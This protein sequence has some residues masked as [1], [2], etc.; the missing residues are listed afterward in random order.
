M[1][2]LGLVFLLFCT[3]IKLSAKPSAEFGVTLVTSGC[4]PLTVSFVDMSSGSPTSWSWDF[5]NGQTSILQDPTVTFITAG[6]YTIRLTATN[7]T[8]SDTKTKVKYITVFRNPEADFKVNKVVACINENIVFTDNSKQGDA[9]LKDWYWFFGDGETIHSKNPTHAYKNAGIYT[10]TLIVTDNNNCINTIIKNNLIEIK[11]VKAGFYVNSPYFCSV[12]AVAIFTNLSTPASAITKFSWNF[13]DGNTSNS[14]NPTNPYTKNGKY[15]VKLKVEDQFGCS[16]EITKTN[17]IEVEKFIADFDFTIND[18]CAPAHVQFTNKST[19]VSGLSYDWDFGNGSNTDVEDPGYTY[20]NPGNY[21]V[22]LT[23]SKNGCSS[24]KTKIVNVYSVPAAYFSADTQTFCKIPFN[25]KFSI[26]FP[27][28]YSFLWNF[29]DN[30]SSTTQQPTHQYKSFGSFSVTLR[31]TDNSTGCTKEFVKNGYIVASPPDVKVEIQDTMGCV[32]LIVNYKIKDNSLIPFT[33]WIVNSGNGKTSIKAFDYFA[34]ADTGVFNLTIRGKNNRGCDFFYVKQIKV[35]KHPIA[36]FKNFFYRG[37]NDSVLQFTNLTNTHDPKADEF[38][39]KFGDG[40]TSGEENPNHK[41]QDTGYMDVT[42]IASKYG[43]KDSTVHK[44][45]VYINP[46]IAII[47]DRVFCYPAVLS[48]MNMSKGGTKWFWD[49]GDHT[50]STLKNPTHSYA[51]GRYKVVLTVEDENTGCIDKDS[52]NVFV[53]MPPTD[54]FIA[55]KTTACKGSYINF[56]DISTNYLT[57][58]W[59]FGNG[60]SSNLKTPSINY[61]DGGVYTVSLIVEDSNGCKTAIIKNEYIKISDIKPS[62]DVTPKSGCVPLYVDAIDKSY[63]LIPIKERKWDFGNSSTI[64]RSYDED[65]N[66]TYIKVLSNKSQKTGFQITL[67]ITDSIGCSSSISQTVKP[68]D[69]KAYLNLYLNDNCQTTQ[70]GFNAYLNDSNVLAP[71]NLKWYINHKYETDYISFN[72]YFSGNDTIPITLVMTDAN[73][74]IDSANKD[75]VISSNPPQADYFY[76]FNPLHNNCPPVIVFFENR[77]K[78]GKKKIIK[79]YWDF[80]NNTFST[81][82]SPSSSYYD[83]GTY[84]VSLIVEDEVGCKDTLLKPYIIRVN[85]ASGYFDIFPPKGCVPLTCTYIAHTI[86]AVG[87]SWNFGD[88]NTS[89]DSITTHDYIYGGVFKPIMVL[90][91]SLGCITSYTT[92]DSIIVYNNPR[93]LFSIYGRMTCLGNVT[94]FYNQT[95]HEQNI[96]KWEWDLGDGYQSNMFEPTYAYKDTGIYDVSLKVTDVEGCKDSIFHPGIVDIYYDTIKPASPH[97]YKT[98]HLVDEPVLDEILFSKNHDEDF[99]NVAIFRANRTADAFSIRHLDLD[100]RDTLVYDSIFPNHIP[101]CYYLQNYDYCNNES[102]PS[103]LHCLIFLKVTPKAEG[104]QLDWNAYEGWDSVEKYTI[105]RKESKSSVD[106]QPIAEVDANTLSYL[107]TNVICS[108]I[109]KYIV[110]GQEKNGYQQISISNTDSVKATKTMHIDATNLIRVSVEDEKVLVEW[111]KVNLNYGYKYFIFRSYNNLPEQVHVEADS[112]WQRI[113]DKDVKC[114]EYSYIYRIKVLQ[115][116]CKYLGNASNIGQSILLKISKVNAED[117]LMLSWNF[118]KQWDIGVDHYEVEYLNQKTNQFD[119]V[120]YTHPDSNI[121]YHPFDAMNLKHYYRVRAVQR[122][123]PDIVSNSN[124]ASHILEPK[125]HIPNT[126]TPD[127]DGLNDYFFPVCYGCKVIKMQIFSRWGELLFES[128][129]GDAK[130]DGSFKGQV[131]PL[132]VYVYVITVT[133]EEAPKTYTG[134]ITIL[135]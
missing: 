57:Y 70:V 129:A 86:R 73:G 128:T 52:A 43:C 110:S 56:K 123:N 114:N 115:S 66:Y 116:G 39:W 9:A 87:Y 91:D 118:Y 120:G 69:P 111:D 71:A 1:R 63:S 88:G 75:I 42:L 33:Q 134:D 44:K 6:T 13:G 20:N 15:T 7:S 76:S 67:T 31:I 27:G 127:N 104:N 98:S 94:K 108:Y 78:A 81:K 107:D 133:T 22:K 65:T 40:E 21:N 54:D 55:D 11:G 29:G 36:E 37:C 125:V 10:V 3:I 105:Y 8:G 12:P 48:N 135:R 30:T 26:F 68:S 46:P 61:P 82:E 119:I 18:S 34:Y 53:S 14:S 16:D 130:W 89:K 59:N 25:V 93:A 100:L 62:F 132:G 124:I 28:N 92:K 35:G 84:S 97:V 47:N 96:K 101:Q 85:G 4:S 49:F 106:Y 79:Y 77:S 17:Y 126:F 131:C 23:I 95:I 109:Y 51:P 90:K 45:M 112:S 83:P 72:R 58:S 24:T 117:K 64:M 80:G 103:K 38:L 5:G 50:Y 122:N 74:C 19:N 41:Y 32:P 113:L 102:T 121:F 2:Y 60:Q 99:R